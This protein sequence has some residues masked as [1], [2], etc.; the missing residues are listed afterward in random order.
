MARPLRLEFAGA[1]YHVTSRGDGRR[2][3]LTLIA[4]LQAERTVVLV[5]PILESQVTIARERA[6]QEAWALFVSDAADPN[7]ALSLTLAPRRI[8]PARD[9]PHAARVAAGRRD[10]RRGR[11][12]SGCGPRCGGSLRAPSSAQPLHAGFQS[13]AIGTAV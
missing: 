12:P 13:G 2:T 1:L 10:G 11:C 7:H 9:P 4:L 6:S 5:P 3:T 8:P